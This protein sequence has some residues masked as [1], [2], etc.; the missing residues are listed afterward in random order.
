[1]TVGPL[2]DIALIILMQNVINGKR[3]VMDIVL[4]K[5]NIQKQYFLKLKVILIK[6]KSI[7]WRRKYDSRNA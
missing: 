1:M 3:V 4:I 2:L 7:L 6:K 5:M